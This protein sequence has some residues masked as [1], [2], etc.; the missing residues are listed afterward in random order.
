MGPLYKSHPNLLISFIIVGQQ[1][2]VVL[3]NGSALFSKPLLADEILEK[4]CFSGAAA[5]L[6]GSFKSG[7]L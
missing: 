2:M 1:H 4:Q 6:S 3:L 5:S 7:K